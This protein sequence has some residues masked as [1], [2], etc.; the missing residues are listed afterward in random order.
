MPG[1]SVRPAL[2]RR[3]VRHTSCMVPM[4]AGTNGLPIRGTDA[5]V[6]DYCRQEQRSLDRGYHV[7]KNPWRGMPLTIHKDP[8]RCRDVYSTEYA[9]NFY[10][11]DD[12]VREDDGSF[13]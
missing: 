13:W 3:L 2:A 9:G 6:V 12:A 1:T 8:D 5:G 11:G 4:K 7:I 10:P